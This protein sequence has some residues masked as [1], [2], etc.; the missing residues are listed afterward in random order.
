M[1]TVTVVLYKM[2]EEMLQELPTIRTYTFY[3][4]THV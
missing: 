3:Q 4:L 2:E 1:D